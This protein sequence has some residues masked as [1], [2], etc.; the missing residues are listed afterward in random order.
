MFNPWNPKVQLQEIIFSKGLSG[1]KIGKGIEIGVNSHVPSNSSVLISK[2]CF[3]HRNITPPCLLKG[4]KRSIKFQKNFL[5]CIY[6]AVINLHLKV[7]SVKKNAK[8]AC[9]KWTEIWGP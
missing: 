6:F 7:I 4:K 9:K 5:F 2:T 1:V 8:N 3:C